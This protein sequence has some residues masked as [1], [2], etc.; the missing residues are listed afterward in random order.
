MK[1]FPRELS[2]PVVEWI[3]KPAEAELNEQ[4][5]V[6]RVLGLVSARLADISSAH[7]LAGIED[8]MCHLVELL[9]FDRCTFSEFIAGDYLSVLCSSA[10]NNFAPLPIGRLKLRLPWLQAQLRAGKTVVLSNLPEDLPAEATDEAQ[11]CRDTGLRS[12]L[13]IPVRVGGRVTCVLSLAAASRG[14]QWSSET[15]ARLTML[16]EMLGCLL[17]LARA[18]EEA[19]QL[20]RRVWHADRV[21]RVTALHT[22]IAHE[23]SQPLAAILSNAQAGL[24]DLAGEHVDRQAITEILEAVVHEDK[25]AAG[26]IRAMRELI[27]KDERQR[28]E[29]DLVVAADEVRRLLAGEL[30]SQG[31]QVDFRREG[32]HW[33]LANRVQIEQLCLNLLLNAAAAVQCRAPSQRVIQLKLGASDDQVSLEVLDAGQGIASQDLETIFEPFWTTREDGLGLGLVI[34]RSIVEAHGG[35]IW[36]ESNA[37]GG[38]TFCVRLPA[39]LRRG[40]PPPELDARIEPSE[41]GPPARHADARQGAVVCVIDDDPQVRMSMLRLLRQAGW[42]AHAWASAEAYLLAPFDANVACL[43]LDLNMPGMSGRQLQQRLAQQ[44]KAPAIVFVTGRGDVAAGIEAMKAGAQDY[45]QKPVDA[46]LLLG[47]VARAVEGHQVTQRQSALNGQWRE[48]MTRLSAR[49]REIMAH[50]IRGRLNKQ[51]AAD[52]FIAEQTVK[53]HRG[54]VMEKMGV[55]SVAELVRICGAAGFADEVFP[56]APE[57]EATA[58]RACREMPGGQA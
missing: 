33:V 24:K 28:E 3:G 30:A 10:A 49:E 37:R 25:R 34:C 23:L 29:F 11:H 19:A 26:T 20:R 35:R 44:G 58:G 16:G 42:T 31:V 38:A 45:L 18:E 13:S 7:I 8:A 47:A 40:T 50:V 53:Q 9:K 51:I 14:R 48:R 2:N 39:A 15:I 6:E 43:L 46:E 54:R 36:A 41:S 27:R 52:L 1:R 22:A 55:R 21:E 17:A 4:V 32:Q 56:Q 5:E 57:E 12:H